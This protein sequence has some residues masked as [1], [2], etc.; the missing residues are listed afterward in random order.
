MMEKYLTFEE[1][2][3]NELSKKS[4]IKGS[5]GDRLRRAQTVEVTFDKADFEDDILQVD[6]G[7]KDLNGKS[8]TTWKQQIQVIEFSKDA[9]TKDDLRKAL[10]G[11]LKVHCNC[12]DFLYKGFQYIGTKKDYSINPESIA[13]A[14]KNPNLEGTVCKHLL[15]VL[16]KLDNFNNKIYKGIE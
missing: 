10:N 13:P 15:A 8:G 5:L 9:N 4:L 2:E 7:A 11:N 16:T 12:P 14:E 1:F 3:I 6:F